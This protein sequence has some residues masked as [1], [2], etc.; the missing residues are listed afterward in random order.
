MVLM[1][2]IIVSIFM[3]LIGC[4]LRMSRRIPKIEPS[5]PEI[6][7]NSDECNYNVLSSVDEETLGISEEVQKKTSPNIS[8]SRTNDGITFWA[9]S[10]I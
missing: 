9:Q 10:S 7:L 6:L 2:L 3:K 5:A 4:S 8:D 1:F